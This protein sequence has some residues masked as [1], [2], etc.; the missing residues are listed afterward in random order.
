MQWMRPVG[1]SKRLTYTKLAADATTW[2]ECQ[3]SYSGGRLQKICECHKCIVE[4]SNTVQ[5]L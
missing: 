3:D 1:G 2:L 4:P 5:S